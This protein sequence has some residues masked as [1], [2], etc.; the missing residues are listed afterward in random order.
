MSTTLGPMVPPFT[1]SSSCWL[2]IVMV[3]ETAVM[4]V[5]FLAGGR[6]LQAWIPSDPPRSSIAIRPRQP[7]RET[8]P[9]GYR[10]AAVHSSMR[11]EG[12]GCSGGRFRN[13]VAQPR[14]ALVAAEHRHH[15]EQPRR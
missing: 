12:P 11:K 15:V 10:I 13:L 8:W 4:V 2:S 6:E 7:G 5:A 3:V 14:D 9:F 1:G